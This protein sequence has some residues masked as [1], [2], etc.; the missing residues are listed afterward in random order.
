MVLKPGYQNSLTSGTGY[1]C[2]PVYYRVPDS[3]NNQLHKNQNPEKQNEKQYLRLS[4][5]VSC[6]ASGQQ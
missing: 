5:P 3:N 4:L 1:A 2:L 6:I